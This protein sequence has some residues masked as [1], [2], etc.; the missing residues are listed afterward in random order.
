MIN[1]YG[2]FDRTL[3][4]FA[5]S[6]HA[7][8]RFGFEIDNLFI[9]TNTKETLCG[10]HV[11]ISGLARSGSTIL[12]RRF[13]ETEQYCSLT[14]LDMP[15]VNMPNVWKSL[16]LSIKKTQNLKSRPHNDRIMVTQE[17]PESFDEIF[18]RAFDQKAY[19]K[20]GCLT[21]H[22]PDYE[23]LQRFSAYIHAIR[24]AK[25]TGTKPY[26]SKNNNNILR[27]TELTKTFTNALF[28]VPFRKPVEHASSLLKQHQNFMHLQSKDKFIQKYM[29]WLSHFE[30]GFG[31]LPFSLS[32]NTLSD[33][34][35]ENLNYWLLQWCDVYEWLLS[36]WENNYQF[37]C[38]EN[39]CSD[40][41]YWLRIAKLAQIDDINA[42]DNYF[43]PPPSYR[44]ACVEPWIR[45]RSE[46]IY[47]KLKLLSS[48]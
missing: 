43:V 2:F 15:F 31:H 17:S 28:L 21:P 6:N 48:L 35:N 37:I 29:G 32:N 36:Q 44:S 16:N 13:Y 1:E 23:A 9:D 22:N 10:N 41:K 33:Y 25:S 18:W 30:F 26:L 11:F 47:D 14:Y 4:A 45:R 38:Y 12:M 19:V 24:Q 42:S 27:I 39:L 20:D 34:D 46:K 3:H 8:L 5:L 7:A 40:P